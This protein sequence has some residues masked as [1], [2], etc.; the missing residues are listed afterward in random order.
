MAT[1]AQGSD[2]GGYRAEFVSMLGRLLNG[3]RR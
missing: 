1:A 3:E 2:D